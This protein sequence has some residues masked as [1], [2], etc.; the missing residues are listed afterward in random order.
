MP[1]VSVYLCAWRFDMPTI[2]AGATVALLQTFTAFWTHILVNPWIPAR[3][4][5]H[6]ASYSL[7]R[8]SEDPKKAVTYVLDLMLP[9][10]P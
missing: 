4:L 2:E 7:L 6:G 5:G 10:R 8:G 9:G 3:A 1:N